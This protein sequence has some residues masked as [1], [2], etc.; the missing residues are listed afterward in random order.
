M[1]KYNTNLIRINNQILCVVESLLTISVITSVYY[2]LTSVVYYILT[3]VVYYVLTSVYYIL[4]SVYYILTSVVYYILTSVYYS[5]TSVCVYDILIFQI[6]N[7]LTH[8]LI[9]FTVCQ[10]FQ[11]ICF[12]LLTGQFSLSSVIYSQQYLLKH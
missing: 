10:I 4:T 6:S 3:S 2:I 8:F 9:L 7:L 5:L 11:F 12:S 1:L